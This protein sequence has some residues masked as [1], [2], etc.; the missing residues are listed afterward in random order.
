MMSIL[1]IAC[2]LLTMAGVL[3]ANEYATPRK[4]E[5]VI[6]VMTDGLRWQEVFTGAD[7]SL[8]TM[9][10]GVDDA[11]A[12]GVAKAFWRD[13]PDARRELVLPF[14]S[15]VMATQGQ[16][17]GNRNLKSDMQVTNGLK[18]SYPGYNE[19]LCGY[20]DPRIDRNE[21]GP[22]PNVTVLEWLAGKA[23]FKGRVAAFAAWDAFDAIINRDRCGFFVNAGFA[24][25]PAA[26]TNPQ[27]DLLNRL[28]AEIPRHWG[29]EPVDALTFYSALDYFK[30]HQPRIFFLSLGETDEWGHGGQYAAYLESAKRADHYVKSLWETA[31]ALPQ[32]QGKTTLLFA[33][34]HGR[35]SGPVA[36][37]DHGKDVEG[38]EYTWLAVLGPD[39]PSLGERANIAVIKQ[40]RIAATIAA[41][42]G[43]NFCADVPK[44]AEPIAA[45]LG[46]A[47]P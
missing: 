43:E 31:Q 42:L 36:W 21:Y 5:N 17:F 15:T 35:G 46:P 37:K 7:K 29:E 25:L 27:I 47:L 4:T 30:R 9:G 14:V 2:V 39:T 20:P 1:R 45:V 44:A 41:L 22:N 18:F 34:D 33:A 8:M 28:K 16:I 23:A 24:P 19:T 13:A 26:E 40:G 3:S 11:A 10:N 6:F 12:R 32:Y 38:A